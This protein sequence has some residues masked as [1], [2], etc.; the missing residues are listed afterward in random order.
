MPVHALAKDQRTMS[1]RNTDTTMGAAIKIAMIPLSIV[2]YFL[3]C[4][5]CGHGCAYHDP[6]FRSQGFRSFER[7][8][9]LHMRDKDGYIGRAKL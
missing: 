8:G 6:S 3:F 4:S 1:T 9:Y 5:M 2:V 7:G